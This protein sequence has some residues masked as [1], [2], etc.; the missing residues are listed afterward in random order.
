[1]KRSPYSSYHG[2]GS[3]L[4]RILI[5]IVILLVIALAVALVG[6]FVLP[7]YIVYTQNGPQL[8][9]PFFSASSQSPQTA[10][11]SP[12]E[13]VSPSL[14]A[15]QTPGDIVIEPLPSPSAKPSPSR[16]PEPLPPRR[17]APLGLVPYEE[18]KTLGAKQGFLFTADQVEDFTR[19]TSQEDHDY[20]A[21]YVDAEGLDAETLAETCLTLVDKAVDE[22]VVSGDVDWPA[23]RKAL[24]ADYFHGYLSAVS[25]KSPFQEDTQQGRDM[26]QYC[27]R[28]YVPGGNWNGLN[29]YKYLKDNGFQGTTAD[30]VT[31][32]N[33]PLS[34]NYA[35][36]VLPPQST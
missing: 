16:S 20:V 22:L 32:V 25:G 8:V 19:S 29:L 33:K 30:I 1:M 27:D 6:L 35:W 11:P 9:I 28:V 21:V 18:G 15:V 14:D 12:S 3:W 10:S 4:R 13:A 34:T 24:P 17:T 2:R 7:N 36:A 5:A 31:T 26:A 23:L